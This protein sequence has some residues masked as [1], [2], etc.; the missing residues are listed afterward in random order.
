[1]SIT[2]IAGPTASG[3]TSLGVRLAQRLNGEVISCDSMQIYKDIPICSAQP[4]EEERCNIPHHL[5][6]FLDF[7]ARFTVADYREL[8]LEKIRDVLSRGKQ[9]I[10][11]G[12]TGMYFHYLMYE[13]NF[14]VD[15]D[16]VV[17]QGL[18]QQTDEELFAHLV[19]LD[20]NTKISKNDRKRIVRALE[21]YELT[22]KLPQEKK[23]ERNKEFDFKLYCISP[24]REVLYEKINK[25][26]DIMLENGMVDEI[27]TLYVKGIDESHQCYKAIGC[28]QLIDYFEGR[29]TFAEAVEN[30]KRES[31]R[32]AK[33]QLTWMRGEKSAIWLSSADEQEKVLSAL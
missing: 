13:P 25:R 3:K 17:K 1:M 12:G 20:A 24:E 6:G 8:A 4:T 16:E 27:R 2:V 19:S 7:T 32:Y 33:R 5:M 23:P 29:V 11:V 14:D 18:L 28:R 9:P 15:S 26:V 10:I 31:R 22:G 21:V 30:I